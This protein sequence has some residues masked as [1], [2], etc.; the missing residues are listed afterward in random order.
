MGVR[1]DVT[2]AASS[3]ALAD[4]V[5]A[6]FGRVD[7]LVNNAGISGRTPLVE[8]DEWTWDLMI[9][10]N[11]TGVQRTTRA[12]APLMQDQRSGSI[13]NISSVVGRSGKANMTHSSAS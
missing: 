7:V 2:D 3:F 5:V 13:V 9:R 8:M 12:I 6:E 10:V 4:A 11:L 1:H